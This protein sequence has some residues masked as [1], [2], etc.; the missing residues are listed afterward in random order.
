MKTQIFK[1][2]LI[3]LA[4]LTVSSC[5]DFLTEHPKG[6]LTSESAFTEHSDLISSV[7]ALYRLVRYTSVTTKAF[8]DAIK[9]DDI[10]THPTN[11]ATYREYDRFDV[12]DANSCMSN[13]LGSYYPFWKVIKCANYIINGADQTPDTTEDELV[14]A[15][16]Q[17]YYWRAY[18]YF[19]LV[20]N[21]G[22]IP[23]VTTNDVDY[24]SKLSSVEDVYKL[25]VSDLQESERLPENYTES[26]WALNGRN[27]VVSRAAAESTLGYVY[28]TMAGWPLNLGSEYYEKAATELKKVIDGVEAGTYYYELFDDFKNIHSKAYNYNNKEAILSVY[29]SISFGEGDDTYDSRGGIQ[30][31]PE[32]AGGWNTTSAEIKFWSKFPEGPRKDAT[33]GSVLYSTDKGMA[34]DWWNDA[35]S[36]KQPYF[37][38]SAYTSSDSNDEYDITK[39][40]SSQASGWQDQAHIVVRLA[41]VNCWYAEAIGRSGQTNAKAFE[42]LNKVIKRANSTEDL[43]LTGNEVAETLAERAYDEH[44]WEIAGWYWSSIGARKYDQERMDRLKDHF[45][46]RVTNDS[47]KVADGVFLKEPIS[48]EGTW[49][50]LMNY[51]PYPANEV[52]L[53]SNFDNT[54]RE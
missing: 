18:A 10:S 27:I 2:F 20:R 33:Y 38:K 36:H 46:E 50:D 11:K 19:F 34:F 44:G 40:Y 14:F 29:F 53:N 16:G 17:A 13:T 42:V 41:E 26:P 48:V 22:P 47:I 5:D 51:S 35:F 9:G 25:I 43:P 49:N 4:F 6:Q 23:I 3:V 45:E 31:I 52:N 37:I 28:M 32:E 39:S 7:N 8:A 12:S 15:K 54:G 1:I 30:D 21:W 24:N